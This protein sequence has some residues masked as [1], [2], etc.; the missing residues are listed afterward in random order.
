[1]QEVEDST[2]QSEAF[3]V[4]SKQVLQDKAAEHASE[5]GKPGMDLSGTA[6]Q[7]NTTRKYTKDFLKAT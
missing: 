4:A 1:M 2:S 3:D 5:F 6:T 7:H